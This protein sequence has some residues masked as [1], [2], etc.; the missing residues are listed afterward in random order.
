MGLPLYLLF[1]VF[2]ILKSHLMLGIITKSK[3]INLLLF[4]P[5]IRNLAMIP[6]QRE[7]E[8]IG[9]GQTK[10]Y[11]YVVMLPLLHQFSSRYLP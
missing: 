5:D 11:I 6:K 3:A 1:L 9:M 8:I 2:C 4:S 7:Y 10:I